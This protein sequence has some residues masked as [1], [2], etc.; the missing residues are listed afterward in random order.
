MSASVGLGGAMLQ[1]IRDNMQG[2]IAKIIIGLIVITF[3]LFGID[4]IFG[5]ATV[6]PAVDV[7]GVEI[8][9]RELQNAILLEKRKLAANAGANFNPD[10]LDDKL[11][12]PGVQQRLV[13]RQLLIEYAGQ[14]NLNVS[15]Q[16][17]D[18]LIR[19]QADFQVDGV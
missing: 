8:S 12:R 7:N 5:G 11:L 15:K 9:E 14:Q 17:V 16:V 3:A 4:S 1:N 2:A 13:N 19:Q 18:G 6:Q 10:L